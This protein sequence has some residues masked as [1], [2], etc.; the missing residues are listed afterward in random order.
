MFGNAKQNKKNEVVLSSAKPDASETGLLDST[1]SGRSEHAESERIEHERWKVAVDA[2]SVVGAITK[3][4]LEHLSQLIRNIERLVGLLDECPISAGL[5]SEWNNEYYEKASKLSREIEVLTYSTRIPRSLI[6]PIGPYDSLGVKTLVY[7]KFLHKL[8]AARST[9]DRT[10]SGYFGNIEILKFPDQLIT[11]HQRVYEIFDRWTMVGDLRQGV[12]EPSGY[13][14]SSRFDERQ[15]E[16]ISKGV[17]YREFFE[18]AYKKVFTDADQ[19]ELLKDITGAAIVY[20]RNF[21]PELHGIVSVL[22]WIEASRRCYATGNNPHGMEDLY[23]EH[24]LA[25]VWDAGKVQE[26]H[27]QQSWESQ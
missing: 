13:M 19:K 23:F 24:E 15:V 18:R 8:R 22:V 21:R 25:K 9:W 11:F 5:E 16:K 7:V 2:N 14:L 1:K 17:T 26:I 27:S 4:T 10:P 12:G 20:A 6:P 3:S